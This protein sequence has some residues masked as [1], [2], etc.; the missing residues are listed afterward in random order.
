[1]REMEITMIIGIDARP[2][3][4][5]NPTGITNYLFNILS[6]FEDEKNKFILYVCDEIKLELSFKFNFVVKKIKSKISTFC[7]YYKLPKILYDDKVDVFWGSEHIL[8]KKNKYTKNIKFICT[9]HDI[10][11]IVN[12]LAGSLKNAIMQNIYCKKSIFNAD[13][14]LTIS[15]STRNEIIRV[16]PN[17]NKNK[18]HINPIGFDLMT[19]LKKAPLRP[20]IEC[21]NFL[22][23][24]GTLDTRKNICNIIK[25]FFDYKTRIKSNLKLVLAGG[26]GNASKEAFKLVNKSKYSNDVIFTGYI[27]KEEKISLLSNCSFFIFPS[28]YEGFGIPILEAYSFGKIV[29]VANNS[30]LREVAGDFAP[31]VENSNDYI[32]ISKKIEEIISYDKK[33]VNIIKEKIGLQIEKFSWDKCSKKTYEHIIGDVYE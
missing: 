27:T 25:A 33:E 22:L 26:N 30:S 10:A 24:M 23:F 5:N 13:L 7:I 17:V 1:M 4:E 6:R 14:I 11:L 29:L 32:S 18:I 28:N 16:F 3:C 9:I 20:N 21:D 19:G 8:P 31:Y 2:L 15:N 12:P